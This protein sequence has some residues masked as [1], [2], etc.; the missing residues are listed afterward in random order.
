MSSPSSFRAFTFRGR[1]WRLDETPEVRARDLATG[2]VTLRAQEDG[3]VQVIHTADEEMPPIHGIPPAGELYKPR[4]FV[5]A[6]LRLGFDDRWLENL[7]DWALRLR[8]LD[9]PGKKP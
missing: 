9:Y 2:D 4:L 6:I 3:N 1:G 8:L 7:V 5:E